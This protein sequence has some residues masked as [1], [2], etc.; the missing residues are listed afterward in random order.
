MI[1]TGFTVIALRQT[2]SVAF[3]GITPKYDSKVYEPRIVDGIIEYVDP[4]DH[5]ANSLDEGGLFDP[6]DTVRIRE[7]R[8]DSDAG[9][10]IVVVGDRDNTDHDVTVYTGAGGY[11]ALNSINVLSSQIIKITSEDPGWIDVY[12][13]KGYVAH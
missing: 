13:V 5:A 12:I 6:G 1:P 11:V 4:D 10:L 8:S 7:I 3:T 9:D 2:C